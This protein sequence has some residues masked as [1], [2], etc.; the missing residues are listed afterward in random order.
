MQGQPVAKPDQAVCKG[1]QTGI[2]FFVM[3][4]QKDV[5]GH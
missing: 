1:Q 3:L 4:G 5:P 2:A